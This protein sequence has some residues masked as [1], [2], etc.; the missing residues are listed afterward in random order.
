MGQFTRGLFSHGE[1]NSQDQLLLA[2][3]LWMRSSNADGWQ[4]I[5]LDNLI[6]ILVPFSTELK[7]GLGIP[8]LQ[9]GHIVSSA[10][11][12]WRVPGPGKFVYTSDNW[13]RE[14]DLQGYYD[15]GIQLAVHRRW[16]EWAMHTSILSL[17]HA[18]KPWSSI[19]KLKQPATIGGIELAE[20]LN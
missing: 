16:L 14:L 19:K 6:K 13:A 17:A 5:G 11:D 1:V 2:V 18:S 12:I 10:G 3:T 7:L 15:T 20:F 8:A 4:L 9:V